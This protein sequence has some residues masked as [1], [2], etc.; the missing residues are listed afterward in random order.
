MISGPDGRSLPEMSIDRRN[1]AVP[2]MR[3][4][5]ALIRRSNR[6]FRTSPRPPPGVFS[7][8]TVRRKDGLYIWIGAAIAALIGNG[9]A[10]PRFK[11]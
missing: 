1:G 7:T 10:R 3:G 11:A 4:K 8:T 9:F 5:A 6:Q 2:Q